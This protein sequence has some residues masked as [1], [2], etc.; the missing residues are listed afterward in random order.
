[1]TAKMN[2]LL[3]V[4]L[5]GAQLLPAQ[6]SQPTWI[7]EHPVHPDFYIGIAMA[8][9]EN[10]PQN[11]HKIAKENALMNLASEISV[12]ISGSFIHE[13]AEKSGM[14]DEEVRQ[15]VH[16]ST[17]A[18]LEGYELVDNWEGDNSYWVYYRLS[19]EKY[20]TIKKRN[21][22]NI[23]ELTVDL[24]KQAKT[25]QQ[26]NNI[27]QALQFLSKALS[28]MES[29]F[30]QP[31]KAQ[32]EDT[33]VI[34]NNYVFFEL[35]KLLNDISVTARTKQI[36]ATMGQRVQQP[37]Q[38]KVNYKDNREIN[39][40]P[41]NVTFIRGGGEVVNT[42]YTNA[43]GTTGINIQKITDS[44]PLQILVISAFV[45]DVDNLTNPL[46]KR[47][48]ENLTI[49]QDRVIIEVAGPS[50]Y[51]ESQEMH[52]G[53]AAT[54]LYLEPKLKNALSKHNFNFTEDLSQADW[55]IKV[56]AESYEG[57]NLYDMYT[58]FLD[59]SISIIDLKSGREIYK[60]SY[61]KIKGV[62]LDYEKASKK[63]FKNAGEKIENIVPDIL[64]S[65]EKMN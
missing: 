43:N 18:Q 52:L 10:N 56:Q 38:A 20:E 58:A 24:L 47:L 44:E 21:E 5:A 6:K 35:Q 13:L 37:V 30:G 40:L 49:P 22:Q 8:D 36:K 64:A 23:R 57:A 39:N 61:S 60:N 4:F 54:L 31:I 7:T 59:F 12:D 26:N 27:A 19:K 17:R 2:V 48:I 65:L 63:A 15:E 42:V 14:I 41:L 28:G 50:V 45:I 62:Q 53:Q 46:L 16:A 32:I 25:A 33:E 9:K 29:R 11:Y 3:Y 1:M 51:I 55:Q 34:L